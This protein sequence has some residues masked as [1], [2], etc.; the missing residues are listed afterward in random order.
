MV[1]VKV[2]KA[3][4]VATDSAPAS[5]RRLSKL[6]LSSKSLVMQTPMSEAKTWERIEF[7]G[8]AKA[9]S[10]TL[11]S[12][13]AAAPCNSSQ[14]VPLSGTR[15]SIY[16]ATEDNRSASTFDKT[17]HKECSEKTSSGKSPEE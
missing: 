2:M 16:I 15:N 9:A 5:H 8:W 7:R 12:S 1:F 14:Y 6:E 3:E 10:I 17:R 4:A 11:N 13:I